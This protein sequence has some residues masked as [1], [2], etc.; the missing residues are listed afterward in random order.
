[1]KND[2]YAIKILTKLDIFQKSLKQGNYKQ[3]K[4]HDIFD[5]IKINLLFLRLYGRYI[6]SSIKQLPRK[7]IYSKNIVKIYSK[8]KKGR[9]KKTQEIDGRKL[10]NELQREFRKRAV[11]A[12]K[13]AMQKHLLLNAWEQVKI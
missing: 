6:K 3:Q 10:S 12:V 4:L 2:V 9:M 7:K 11:K 13:K 8:L 5:L 1:M